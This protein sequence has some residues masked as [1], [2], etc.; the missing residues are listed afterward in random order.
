MPHET[1]FQ[2]SGYFYYYG[3]YYFTE[4]VR[5]LPP[6][7]QKPYAEK[8]AALIVSLAYGQFT[9]QQVG[10]I[11]KNTTDNVDAAN[12]GFV[13]QLDDGV[14]HSFGLGLAIALSCVQ[15]HGGTLTLG[16]RAEGGLRARIL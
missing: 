9:P 14:A 4:S 15:L 13:G 12:P 10:D 11:M 8:L 3:I 16:N 5:L 7:K 6:E 2:I 1:H